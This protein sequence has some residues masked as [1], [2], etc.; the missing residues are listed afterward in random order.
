MGVECLTR[1]GYVPDF[2]AKIIGKA[3]LLK[4]NRM[5]YRKSLTHIKN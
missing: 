2:S 5:D 4:I 3:K 1:D